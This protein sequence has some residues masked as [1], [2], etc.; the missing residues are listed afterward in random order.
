MRGNHRLLSF[1]HLLA[2]AAGG[3]LAT[4]SGLS[5]K[6][7]EAA[8]PG[9]SRAAVSAVLPVRI[10]D[11]ETQLLSKES[12]A[13]T[14]RELLAAPLP[15]GERVTIMDELL[16]TWS[17]VDVEAALH[18]ALA[19]RRGTESDMP[20]GVH[21]GVDLIASCS[22]GIGAH[23]EKVLELVARDAFGFGTPVIRWECYEILMQRDPL[24]VVAMLGTLPPD[25]HRDMTEELADLV[26]SESTDEA[27]RHT[28]LSAI[29]R[30]G[31]PEDI[32]RTGAVIGRFAL[33]AV[34][35][36][37]MQAAADES[38]RNV[39]FSAWA[40]ALNDLDQADYVREMAALPD[41]E[42]AR[43]AADTLLSDSWGGE[44]TFHQVRLAYAAGHLDAVQAAVTSDSFSLGVQA[45]PAEST[46]VLIDW[47]LALPESPL[48]IELYRQA[49][50]G[51][52]INGFEELRARAEAME[53]GWQR[54]NALLGLAHAAI[55]RKGDLPL[56]RDLLEGIHDP[57][58]LR[59]AAV[60]EPDWQ[61]V[62][63]TRADLSEWR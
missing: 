3:S 48:A 4:Y 53:P 25:L 6:S 9:S 2:L 20:D 21:G 58:V 36:E 41:E 19:E 15:R 54:D 12:C 14:W 23:L 18:A 39:Y 52:A 56:Y 62:H 28:L 49:M 34:M 43:L 59:L 47:A 29:I 22:E 31:S 5:N 50:E 7:A 44:N 61:R 57:L 33:P 24:K 30:H 1:T 17:L 60:K 51:A 46:K 38:S 13:G 27:T 42:Q 26:K 35:L 32:R 16:R 11:R 40:T 8:D 10:A 37:K 45:T 63:S 55:W